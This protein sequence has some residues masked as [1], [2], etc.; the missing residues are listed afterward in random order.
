MAHRKF[1]RIIWLDTET[2]SPIKISRGT[3]VYSREVEIMIAAYALDKGSVRTHDCTIYQYEQGVLPSHLPFEL[4]DALLDDECLIVCHNAYFDRTVIRWSWGLDIPAW[5][6]HCTMAQALAHSLPAGL[7]LLANVL[8]VNTRKQTGG[9]DH[10]NLFCM[11]RPKGHKLRRATGVTNPTEW[12]E[13][14]SY[15]GDDVLAMRDCYYAMPRRNYIGE[16]KEL[17]NLDQEINDTGLYIDVE[18][19]KAAVEM[20]RADKVKADAK[21]SALTGGAVT[22]AT[23]RDKFLMH[24]LMEHG[25]ILESLRADELEN[26]LGEDWLPV[27]VKE[28]LKLRILAAMNSTSKYT[29]LINCVGPDNRL[30]GTRQFNGASRTGRSAG[31]IFNPLN[32]RRASMKPWEIELFIEAVR[33]GDVE[34]TGLFAE[35]LR[36]GCS[37]A[38]RGLVIA[39]PGHK[40]VV[41]D[42]AGIEARKAAWLVGEQWKL[43]AFKAFDTKVNGK[44]LG[45]DLYKLGYSESFGVPVET[46]DDKQRQGGKVQELFLQY[47]GGVNAYMSGAISIGLDLEHLAR[48]IPNTAPWEAVAQARAIYQWALKK[49][50]TMGLSEPVYVACET[51]KALWRKANPAF[52]NGWGALESAARSA[53]DSRGKE[54]TACRCVFKLEADYLTVRLPSGRHLMYPT[55]RVTADGTITYAGAKNKQWHRIKTYGGKLLEN[56]TQASSRDILVHSMLRIKREHPEVRIVL[57]VYDEVVAEAPLNGTFNI[58]IMNQILVDNPTWAAGLPLAVEGWEGTRYAKH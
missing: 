51:V 22:A 18:F 8:A 31:R 41:S 55:P 15:A 36:E 54:F 30:R 58:E 23:Q 4:H 2:F 10:I 27:E 9:K 33:Q 44:R 11:P 3:D 34:S 17:W 35:N 6:F 38:T 1:K 53:I 46:V 26:M 16:E 13:F 56:I 5:R 21:I 57:D 42:W 14:M 40:L 7:E 37:N 52:A 29:R 19:A 24:L 28:L 25:V 43:D 49:D 12:A 39:P 50:K 45:P 47:G 20:L 48:V 32:M